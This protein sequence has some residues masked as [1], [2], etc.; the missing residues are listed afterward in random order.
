MQHFGQAQGSPFTIPPLNRLK[1]QANSIK[2]KEIIKGSIP[3]SFL[4]DNPYTNKVL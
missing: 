3:T 2:A 4:T 1:W